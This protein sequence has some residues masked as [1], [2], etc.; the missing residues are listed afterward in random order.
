LRVAGGAAR[1]CVFDHGMAFALTTLL[2]IDLSAWKPRAATR[3][4]NEERI[5]AEQE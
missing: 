3:R 4:K 1:I 2:K 5:Y